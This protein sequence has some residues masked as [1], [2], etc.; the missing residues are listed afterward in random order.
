MEENEIAAILWLLVP[1]LSGLSISHSADLLGFPHRTEF[2]F[3]GRNSSERCPELTERL[4][5]L[6]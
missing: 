5:E 2:N 4:Q 1:E 6:N 3:V